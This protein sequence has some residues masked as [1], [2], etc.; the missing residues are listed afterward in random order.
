[1][2][3]AA[4]AAGGMLLTDEGGQERRRVVGVRRP[5][6]SGTRKAEPH[7]VE[8]LCRGRGRR[9]GCI[10]VRLWKNFRKWRT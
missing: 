3:E 4:A 9:V 5:A 8:R 10:D 2:G 1:M 7:G 6:A